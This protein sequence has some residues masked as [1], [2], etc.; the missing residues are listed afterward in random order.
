MFFLGEISHALDLSKPKIMFCS[1]SVLDTISNMVVEMK[2]IQ[3][4]IVINHCENLPSHVIKMSDLVNVPFTEEFQPSQFP[5][6]HTSAIFC[7]SGTTGLPKG[8]M[9]THTN[10]QAA[11]YYLR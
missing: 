7:S 8:V 6:D 4:I 2:S 9:V 5:P 10:F 3:K 11:L 1:E